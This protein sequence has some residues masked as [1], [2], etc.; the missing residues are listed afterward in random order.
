[1]V[2]GW[3]RLLELVFGCSLVQ[4][5]VVSAI[6]PDNKTRTE[7]WR[8]SFSM[9]VGCAVTFKVFF[10]VSPHLS[11]F[12]PTSKIFNSTKRRGEVGN[13]IASLHLSKVSFFPLS[14]RVIMAWIKIEKE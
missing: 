8:E 11:L 12:K 1:M 14:A 10:R 13:A 9:T 4:A 2:D 6:T 5:T 3:G 7:L